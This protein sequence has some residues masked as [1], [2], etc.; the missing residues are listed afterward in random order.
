[1]YGG[2]VTQLGRQALANLA[3]GVY[4]FTM[5]FILG[6][7]IDKT[8]GFRLSEDDEVTGVD[9][10]EHAETAYDFLAAGSGLRGHNT[11]VRTSDSAEVEET[12][13]TEKEGAKV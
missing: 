9:Q 4:S 5:A 13:T 7:I 8:I 6:K 3:V 12:E 2:G 1:F 11:V 10:V